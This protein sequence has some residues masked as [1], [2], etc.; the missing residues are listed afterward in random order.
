M[1]STTVQRDQFYLFTMPGDM[2]AVWA[3]TFLADGTHVVHRPRTPRSPTPRPTSGRPTRAPPWT[4]CDDARD[5][6]EV[7][8]WARTMPARADQPVIRRPAW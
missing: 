2:C 5:L 1:T 7:R 8:E 6:A 4:S 3:E